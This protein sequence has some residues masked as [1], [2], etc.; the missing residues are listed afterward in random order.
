MSTIWAGIKYVGME[1]VESTCC[2]KMSEDVA[3]DLHGHF[4]LSLSYLRFIFSFITRFILKFITRFIIYIFFVGV[5]TKYLTSL[6]MS[7]NMIIWYD[8][9]DCV[10]L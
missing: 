9:R 8:F 6:C 5:G 10:Q 4:L 2:L 7:R 1:V 3:A